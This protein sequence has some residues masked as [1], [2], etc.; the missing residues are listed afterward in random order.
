MTNLASLWLSMSI[1]KRVVLV[2]AT[3]GMFLAVLGLARMVR[4]LASSLLYSGLDPRAA[5]EVVAALD[6][7][8]VVTTCEGRRSTSRRPCAMGCECNLPHKAAGHR[9]RRLRAARRAFRVRDHVT[10]VRRCLLRA[11][12]GELARTILAMPQVKAARVHIAPAETKPFQ[13]DGSMSASV[14]VTTVTGNLSRE[15]ADAL[16]H[17]VAS[18]VGK[19]IPKTSPSSI[20]SA[21]WCRALVTTLKWSGGCACRRD[22][23]QRGALACCAGGSRARCRR[24]V[25]GRGARPESISEKTIDPQGRVA[26]STDTEQKSESATE[27]QSAVTVASNL[28]EG[29]GAEGSTGKSESSQSRERVNFEVSETQRNWCESRCHPEAYG[30]G[31]WWTAFGGGGRRDVNL[32]PRS[33][34]ELADLRELVSTAA[35]LDEARG[36]VLTLKSLE[37]LPPSD[38]GTSAEAGFAAMVGPIDTRCLCCNWLFWRCQSAA[39][40]VRGPSAVEASSGR[41]C[42]GRIRCIGFFPAHPMLRARLPLPAKSRTASICRPCRSSISTSPECSLL[43]AG[44]S[45]VPFATADR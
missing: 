19:C 4:P 26:I 28:P 17:L 2:A 10:D 42:H 39:W 22:Q 3:L 29:D 11:K 8:G 25:G 35:G 34:A 43:A 21:D 15:A 31:F 30:C 44:R 40:A 14:T 27:D 33:D 9:R 36:D 45:G 16:R 1:A 13:R 7:A 41:P 20:R 5:G 12:E 24:S 6:Q 18:A 37:F 32:A 38:Q 23:A